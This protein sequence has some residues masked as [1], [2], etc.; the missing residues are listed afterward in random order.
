MALFFVG[1]NFGGFCSFMI[2][3]SASGWGYGFIQNQAA[4]SM[5]RAIHEGLAGIKE[6]RILGKEEFF[7]K[8]VYR[9]A[10]SILKTSKFLLIQTAPRYLFE[11]LVVV[12]V[13]FLVFLN[14]YGSFKGVFSWHF[15]A[16]GVA[17]L[18]LVPIPNIFSS[19]LTSLRFNR[20]A[21]SRLYKNINSFKSST[22]ISNRKHSTEPFRSLKV[23]N[24]RFLYPD[25]KDAAISDFNIEISSG[26]FIGLIGPSGCGKTTLVDILLGLLKPQTGQ[27]YFND[28]IFSENLDKCLNQ[29]AYMY[30]E[31]FLID[32]VLK[33]YSFGEQEA[34]ID[35]SRFEKAIRQAQLTELVNLPLG[36]NT[37][38]GSA[39]FVYLEDS[40][41]VFH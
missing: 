19:T 41:S 34:I 7:Y 25:T 31:V 21:I 16:F 20:D 10:K 23:K 40:V 5:V 32:D 1:I 37:N 28:K 36:T 9:G 13:V 22:E 18:R 15:R 17:S 24:I 27:I 14:L 12:F 39:V 35:D 3:Y 8:T 26:E 33:E 11:A 29:I 38:L 30:R 2:D 4:E 6:I